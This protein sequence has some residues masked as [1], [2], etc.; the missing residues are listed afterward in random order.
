MTAPRLEAGDVLP[1][2][3]RLKACPDPLA[4]FAQLADGGRRPDTLLLESADT[5]TGRD[6]RSILVVR[7]A[8]RLTCRRREVEATALTP[9]GC[10]FLPW[11]ASRAGRAAAVHSSSTAFSASY[12]GPGEEELADAQRIRQ[13]SPLD[14]LRLAAAGPRLIAVPAPFSHFVAGSLAYDLIDLYENL[15]AP[16]GGP[17]DWPTYETWVPDR[18]VVVDHGQRTTTVLATVMGGDGDANYHDA[19]RAVEALTAAVSASPE[20]PGWQAPPPLRAAAGAPAAADLSDDEYAA[21]VRTL[22]SHIAAG[23]IFQAVPSRTFTAPCRDPLRAYA[24]LRRINPSPYMYFLRGGAGVL[25][26]ASPETCVRVAGEPRTV[27]LR[28]IA[29]TMPRHR[30]SGGGSDPEADARAEVALRTDAKELAEHLMLV[31]LARNDVSRVSRAGT[32][33]V[34]RLLDID[35]LSHVLHLVSE[36]AGELEPDCDALHAYVA[37]MNMGTVVGAPKLRAA[38]LLRTL[39]PAARGPY[40]GAVG[41]LTHDGEMD[42]ALVIRSATVRDGVAAVRAGAGVVAASDPDREARE[43]RHKAAAVLDA[44]ARSED[45]HD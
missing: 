36:V 21:V 38:E 26:G 32:R 25:F 13:P 15:P 5:A 35:R 27:T 22:Q 20:A 41:Y 19:V 12:A 29:G 28:P 42:T 16:L 37:S 17:A 33:R 44:V 34:A 4:L 14:L 39:E 18:V 9:N 1:L 23:D 24:E 7:A 8:V 2:T 11:L 40:G 45:A 6:A 43:T 3:R 10:A 31:D 30:A